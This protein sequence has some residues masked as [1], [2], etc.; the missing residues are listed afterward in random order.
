MLEPSNNRIIQRIT[1]K[2]HD[3]QLHQQSSDMVKFWYG[4]ANK[5]EVVL[6]GICKILETNYSMKYKLQLIEYARKMIPK[7]ISM[8]SL[9]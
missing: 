6:D 5:K 1:E 4:E 7:G 2:L 8:D 3:I 9:V